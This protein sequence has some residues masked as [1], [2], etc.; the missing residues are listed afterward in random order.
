LALATRLGAV[1]YSIDE[2]MATLF[3]MD[4][5]QPIKFDWTIERIARCE[6]QIWSDACQVAA[7]G[8]AVVL[9]LGFTTA[10]HRAKFV[11]LARKLGFATEIHVADAPAEERWRRVERRNAERGATYRLAVTREMF[12]FM[13][14]IWEPPTD[15]EIEEARIG[16]M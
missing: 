10:S 7:R 16:R 11:A 5:P 2:W 14:T 9:D 15:V 12:D 6:A 3:W 8:L 13:E 1:R 4:S